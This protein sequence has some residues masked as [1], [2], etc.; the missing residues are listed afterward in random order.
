MPTQIKAPITAVG[1][2]RAV[3]SITFRSLT[4]V[5]QPSSL[6]SEA[7]TSPAGRGTSAKQKHCQSNRDFHFR[8]T[9]HQT[10]YTH[11]SLREPLRRYFLRLN[12]PN[13]RPGEPGPFVP[14]APESMNRE[15]PRR[16]GISRRR[17]RFTK[18]L[19]GFFGDVL[20]A[21]K[22]PPA[23]RLP[24]GRCSGTVWRRPRFQRRHDEHIFRELRTAPTAI[25][26]R[27][28]RLS[29]TGKPF[30]ISQMR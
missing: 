23:P 30:S 26:K 16:S 5:V 3:D 9:A 19:P 21:A 12:V 4:P 10:V 20:Y 28:K 13:A 1:P 8:L 29:V 24:D 17:D 15:R 25:C 2:R 6:P 14:R 7:R 18:V 22:E 11:Q 27:G